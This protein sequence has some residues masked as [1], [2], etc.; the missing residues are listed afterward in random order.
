L[1]RRG[2]VGRRLPKLLDPQLGSG[3]PLRHCL[4]LPR[5]KKHLAQEE[6]L[7]QVA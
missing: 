4:H 2:E 1:R 7:V 3:E 6:A 5:I